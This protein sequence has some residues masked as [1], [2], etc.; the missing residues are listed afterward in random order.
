MVA[1]V[2]LAACHPLR[3]LAKVPGEDRVTLEA[4]C[5]HVFPPGPWEAVHV[6][7]ASLPMQH[8]TALLG[9][10]SA[11][12]PGQ[13]FRSVLMAQE[14]LALFDASYRAGA[15]EIHRALPPFDHDGFGEGTVEDIRLILFPAEG[16]LS[17][18]GWNRD[19]L[20]ACRWVET[21]GTMVEVAFPAQD[22]LAIRRFDARGRLQR[23]AVAEGLDACGFAREI[24]LEAAGTA[25]YHLHLSLV[26]RMAPHC[27]VAVAAAE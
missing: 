3:P 18:V 10:V 14:G 13:G 4:R 24:D 27:S 20:P 11:E 1:T 9:A 5:G 2:V 7:E 22:R 23:T 26:E 15:V 6:I 8:Q 16:E 12:G 21:D 17:E 19:S 25:G